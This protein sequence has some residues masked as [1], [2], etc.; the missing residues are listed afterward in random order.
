[1]NKLCKFAFEMQDCT[2]PIEVKLSATPRPAMADSINIF[3]KDFGAKVGKGYVV[4]PGNLRLPLA[5][6]V[7]AL[8]FVEL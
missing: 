4:Y 7:V 5:P 8:P 1:M 2:I 6:G 3:R